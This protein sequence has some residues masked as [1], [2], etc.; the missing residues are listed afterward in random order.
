MAA[1]ALISSW[2]P[3]Y[4]GRVAG[5]P[6]AYLAFHAFAVYVA[7]LVM[8]P[9]LLRLS[10]HDT[11]LWSAAAIA[12]S[13][14]GVMNGLILGTPRI[15]YAMARDGLFFRKVGEVSPRSRTPVFSLI[16][17]ALWA[18]LLVLSGTYSELLEYVIFAALLFYVL[19]V[20]GHG[21]W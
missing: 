16:V 8:L 17:Q 11:L 9:M 20:T 19:T 21:F 4:Y 14:F 12:L 5:R 7:M 3:V 13:A 1:A 15:L 2:D 10:T 6:W 18:S